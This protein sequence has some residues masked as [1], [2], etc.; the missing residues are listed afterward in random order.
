MASRW[1]CSATNREPDY[2]MA[3]R[4]RFHES[5]HS[6]WLIFKIT[7]AER[8]QMM[9]ES[10]WGLVLNIIT[11]LEY[12]LWVS[13]LDLDCTITE[14]RGEPTTISDHLQGNQCCI[15]MH[16]YA[17]EF[18]KLLSGSES[19]VSSLT[20]NH[21]HRKCPC[22]MNPRYIES[23]IAIITVHLSFF[24]SGVRNK[25]LALI[26]C[27]K[28]K[29]A[30]YYAQCWRISGPAY[31]RTAPG[32][33]CIWGYPWDKTCSSAFCSFHTIDR[34]LTHSN[35]TCYQTLKETLVTNDVLKI[36]YLHFFE[37]RK[38]LL[39]VSLCTYWCNCEDEA[40]PIHRKS[41]QY[42]ASHRWAP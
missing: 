36:S 6:K 29:I 10:H 19:T 22:S 41:L 40:E 26:G 28:T 23:P 30:I 18:C 15:H 2:H 27:P 5:T 8:S 21:M 32:V 37:M 17:N 24:H 7:S 34:S 39:N 16:P 11:S 20:S 25:S 1:H 38:V 12:P 31:I 4:Q 9:Q 33:T 35:F 14:P 42:T 3:A 13:E